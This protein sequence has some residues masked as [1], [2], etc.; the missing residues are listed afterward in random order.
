MLFC[1]KK[2]LFY[3]ESVKIQ[4]H[5]KM[6][7]QRKTEQNPGPNPIKQIFVLKDEI[8]LFSLG[9]ALPQF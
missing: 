2:Y 9:G 6:K 7:K 4:E 5:V 1:L 8:C 3:I